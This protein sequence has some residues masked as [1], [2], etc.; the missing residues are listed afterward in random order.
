MNNPISFA[1]GYVPASN[2]RDDESP[3]G[4]FGQRQQPHTP[5]ALK[6]QK[7]L[8]YLRTQGIRDA[9]V[10]AEVVDRLLAS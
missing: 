9:N 4:G 10:E 8:A 5:Y 1:V 7:E 6:I 3:R 2:I